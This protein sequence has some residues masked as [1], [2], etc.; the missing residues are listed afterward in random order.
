MKE[1]ILL[2]TTAAL[3]SAIPCQ[4][5]VI[6]VDS[7]A[8]GANNGSGWAGAYN[9]LQDALDGAAYGDEIWVAQGMYKPDRDAARLA[10][11][12]DDWLRLSW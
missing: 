11:T 4:A 9:Y 5:E 3:I 1:M 7:A 12:G 8:S 6:Y 2:L 10:G